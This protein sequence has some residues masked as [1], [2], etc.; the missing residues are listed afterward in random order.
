MPPSPA[1]GGPAGA[2]PPAQAGV[3]NAADLS[4]PEFL[5]AVAQLG[6]NPKEAMARLGVRSLENLNLREALESLRRQMVRGGAATAASA[7]PSAPS[8]GGPAAPAASQPSAAERARSAAEPEHEP[9]AAAPPLSAGYFD[10]EE[11]ADITF[12]VDEQGELDDEELDDLDALEDAELVPRALGG[13]P[14]ASPSAAAGPDEFELAEQEDQDDSDDVPDFGPPPARSGRASTS[15]RPPARSAGTAGRRGAPHGV[16]AQTQQLIARLRMA[17]GGGA[18]TSQQRTAYRN[19]IVAELGEARARAL[20]QGVWRVT[21]DTLGIEQYDEL[22]RWGKQDT[23]AEE[24]QLAFAALQ[25]EREAERERVASEHANG[26]APRGP[27]PS[28]GT[29]RGTVRGEP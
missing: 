29:T 16:D 28:R 27:S 23:F 15:A 9:L 17:H 6:L 22:I 2:L 20:V 21:P 7:S 5:A 4:R 18:A 11:E 12:S 10:E 25:A 14:A 24:A 1:R 13:A 8:A 3:A 19:I 26:E